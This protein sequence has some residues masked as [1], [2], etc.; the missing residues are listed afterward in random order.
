MTTL[1]DLLG[2]HE[3]D[4]TSAMTSH[5]RFVAFH[6]ANPRIFVE[7]ETMAQALVTRG[8]KRIG[9]RMLW[10]TLRWNYSVSVASDD[11]IARLNNN[12]VPFYAR[13]LLEVH[14]D[15]DGLFQLRGHD[16][17]SSSNTTEGA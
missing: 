5:E 3:P 10:E 6:H 17:Y 4:V 13:L 7:L 14:P 9:L 1:F 2:I 15:W 11:A 12:H 8:R 16:E